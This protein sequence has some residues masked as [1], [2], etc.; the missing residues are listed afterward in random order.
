M[1]SI[2]ELLTSLSLEE[3]V[4]Q[5]SCAGRCY[6][7]AEVAGDEPDLDA[8]LNRFPHGVGQ[9]GRPSMG[10]SRDGTERLTTQLQA[11]FRD[12]TRAGI[13]ILFNEEGVHGL[14]GGEATV[15][16]AALGLAASW[17][18]ALVEAAYAAVAAECRERGSN[19]VYAPVLDLARDPR[20]GR[21]EETFGEDPYL[22]ATMGVAAVVGLQGKGDRIAPDRVLACAKH[23][24]GHGIPQAGSNAGPVALG[25]RELRR[26]HLMPFAAVI[27]EANVG[28][29]MVAYHELDGIPMHANSR[30]VSEVLRNELGFAG[31][32]SSDGFGVPQLAT[33]HRVADTPTDAARQAFT[34]GIDC[35]VP[36]PV[37]SAALV[38]EVRAGRLS[39]DVID[40]AC[41]NVLNAKHRL[42]LLAPKGSSEP[43]TYVVEVDRSEHQ[44]LAL[45]AAEQAVVLLTND[46]SLLPL[47]VSPTG[48]ILVCGPNAAGAHF[49]GYTDPDAAGVSILEGMRAR[50]K[51]STVAYREGCRITEEPAT[52]ATWWQD[53][54]RLAD[55][56]A[57]DDRIAAAVAAAANADVVVAVIGGNEATHREGWWFDHLGDRSD[58]TMAG[59]QEELVERIAATET[60]TVALVISAGPVDLRRV[61]AAADAVVWSCYPGELG[62]EAIARILAGDTDAA[63][64]LPVTF[65]RSTGQ[66]PIYSG[67]QPSAGRGY[68]HGDAA[69]LFPLGHGL[70]YTTFGLD[71]VRVATSQVTVD[72]LAAGGNVV[73]EVTITNTGARSGSELIRV[74]VDDLIAS[75]A[76]P[77][78]LAGFC[79]VELEPG[80]STTA[81]F[82]LD[83]AAFTLL[84]QNMQSRIEPGE[85]MV[86][87]YAGDQR[88]NVMIQVGDGS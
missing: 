85:F 31:M 74:H 63:G 7:L 44:A 84:D 11:A 6:E 46:N 81:E 58:L 15:F 41:R 86:T 2:D 25:E 79:R 51:T 65:P 53:E 27:R 52:A 70:S 34:A 78:R 1:Q 80:G 59:R 8:L 61:V 73:I 12:R 88:R 20:W 32:V 14:M 54:V 64:R 40:R 45:R 37:G 77:Q 26:D 56:A 23:F 29:I 57:D 9:L 49:G 18:P 30:W 33:V 17:D 75:V 66:I 42:G 67:R 43:G 72:D 38:E 55:P 62:G 68:L 35:E 4:A 82:R 83:A 87:V 24:F 36:E 28:A 47:D 69:P 5:L 10:R 13:G 50:F 22:V 16:P 76:Q 60:P 21:I 48:T 71:S 3:K 19:Y 39:V